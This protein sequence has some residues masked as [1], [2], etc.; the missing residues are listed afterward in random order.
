VGLFT[1]FAPFCQKPQICALVT[2]E[3]Q[4]HIQSL[5][6]EETRKAIQV[7]IRNYRV[8]K[9]MMGRND[10]KLFAV[11]R[12][13]GYHRMLLLEMNMPVSDATKIS[14][15]EV[16]E[17]PGLTYSDEFVEKIFHGPDESYVLLAAFMGANQCGIY[18]VTLPG[19]SSGMV[20]R[21]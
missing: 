19:S 8:L 20:M 5:E 1:T 21:V 17:I 10:N 16:A 13:A 14:V 9:L 15:K 11:G 2:R 18:K 12:R 4:L 7:D 6:E 3:T